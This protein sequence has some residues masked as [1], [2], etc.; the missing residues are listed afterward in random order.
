MRAAVRLAVVRAC[1]VCLHP[2]TRLHARNQQALKHAR[3]HQR[4]LPLTTHASTDARTRARSTFADRYA[5]SRTICRLTVKVVFIKN[6]F[7]EL[8]TRW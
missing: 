1:T 8:M 7:F 2:H 6:F 3:L 4:R 5:R